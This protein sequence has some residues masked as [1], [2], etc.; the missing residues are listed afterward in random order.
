MMQQKE[1]HTH[2][3]V[4]GLGPHVEGTRKEGESTLA[5]HGKDTPTLHRDPS[6]SLASISLSSE[7]FPALRSGGHRELLTAPTGSMGSEQQSAANTLL[8]GGEC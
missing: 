6:P 2:H 1:S 7:T 8:S 5:L 3:T 4:L